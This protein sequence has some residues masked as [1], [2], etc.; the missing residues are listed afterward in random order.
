[1][2]DGPVARPVP[3]LGLLVG[4]LLTVASAIGGEDPFAALAMTRLAPPRP[5]RDFT[6]PTLP[7]WTPVGWMP[8]EW[9]PGSDVGLSSYRD[10]VVFLNFWATWC[11]P[12]RLEMPAMERVYR[13]YRDKG[14]VVLALSVDTDGRS[15][16]PPFAKERGFSFPI[17]LDSQSRVAGIYR[18][19]ALPATFLLDRHGR[20]VA[21]AI[22]AREWD[23][24]EGFALID[25]I[26]AEP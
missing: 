5:P 22:G 26:L 2:Y 1:M 23:S 15:S 10:H 13:R 14:L 12:C 4:A 8:T 25:R 18:V 17:G 16:V 19:R 11:P 24:P 7:G 20:A 3:G 9:T 6:V 21:Y